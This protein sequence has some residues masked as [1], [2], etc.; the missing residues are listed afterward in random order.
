M[1]FAVPAE[2][3]KDNG[4]AKWV[5]DHGVTVAV[6][7]SA[8][9]GAAI[10]AGIHPMRLTVHADGVNANE[11]V[12]CSGNLGVGRVVANTIE[13]V[14]LLASCAVAHRRQRVVLGADAVLAGAVA[15]VL[16]GPRLD[17]VGLY[18]EISSREHYLA[19][20]PAVISDLLAVMADIRRAHGV[21]L[22]RA[23][24]GGGGFV[25]GEGPA[26]LSEFA[27]TIEVTLDDACAT[28]RFPR[29][30]V[31]VSAAAKPCTR[32]PERS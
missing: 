26:D 12:F 2:V 25:F 30:V 27:E 18:R 24:V 8:D 32:S 3:L 16:N 10:G 13:H 17:L 11:L 29:P 21:I 5:R 6:R 14:G 20:Y 1:E 23:V 4:V 15:A 7:T 9:L 28:L 31:M 22:T 19:G